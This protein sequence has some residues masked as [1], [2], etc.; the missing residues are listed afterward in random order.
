MATFRK[1]KRSSVIASQHGRCE[2][3]GICQWHKLCWSCAGASWCGVTWAGTTGQLS[4]TDLK[5]RRTAAWNGKCGRSIV[6]GKDMSWGYM[7]KSRVSFC[8][9]GRGRSFH[10][11]GLKIEKVQEPSPA[12]YIRHQFRIW[13]LFSNIESSVTQMYIYTRFTLQCFSWW[14][15]ASCPRMSGWH[16]R[17]KLN[18]VFQLSGYPHI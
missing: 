10:V 11:E 14:C 8:L 3:L 17:D 18:Y 4:P 6:L 15:G 2:G 13:P 9:K 7:K 5:R 12:S 16:I 1:E